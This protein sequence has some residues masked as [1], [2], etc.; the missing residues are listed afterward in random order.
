MIIKSKEILHQENGLR[1][2]VSK[3]TFGHSFRWQALLV[4]SSVACGNQGIEKEA[5]LLGSSICYTPLPYWPHCSM[6]RESLSRSKQE[7]IISRCRIGLTSIILKDLELWNLIVMTIE[8]A[9]DFKKSHRLF[10]LHPNKRSG[11]SKY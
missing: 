7:T 10:S 3:P 8:H 9:E 1:G 5:E 11:P 4:A 2:T 6:E